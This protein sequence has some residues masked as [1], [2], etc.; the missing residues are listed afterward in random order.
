MLVCGYHILYTA[1]VG[2]VNYNHDITIFSSKSVDYTESRESLIQF[3]AI[4]SLSPMYTDKPNTVKHVS[5]TQLHIAIQSHEY[6]AMSI[7]LLY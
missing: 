6:L 4:V 3:L 1:Q 5:L 2:M 7:S